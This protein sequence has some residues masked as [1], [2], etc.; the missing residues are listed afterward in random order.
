MWQQF[1]FKAV[2]S[3]LDGGLWLPMKHRAITFVKWKHFEALPQKDCT[4]PRCLQYRAEVSVP[5]F[6]YHLA[7]W[8]RRQI[9]LANTKWYIHMAHV[10]NSSVSIWWNLSYLLRTINAADMQLDATMKLVKVWWRGIRRCCPV[11]RDVSSGNSLNILRFGF[12]L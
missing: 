7:C 8:P 1:A 5:W 3:R 9:S 6:I 10:E 12:Y 11:V 4:L 2:I